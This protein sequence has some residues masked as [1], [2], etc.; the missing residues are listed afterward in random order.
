MCFLLAGAFCFS[1]VFGQST[2]EGCFTLGT[3]FTSS[4]GDVTLV[5]KL[6][7]KGRETA[8][9]LKISKGRGRIEPEILT[10]EDWPMPTH[11]AETCS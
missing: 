10:F 7:T 9:D 5:K 11:T 6:Q 8:Q 1:D 4:S 3:V 2:Q